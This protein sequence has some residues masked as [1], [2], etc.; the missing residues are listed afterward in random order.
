L[1]AAPECI[2]IV[3][4]YLLRKLKKYR[5]NV[6]QNL[7]QTKM[8]RTVYLKENWGWGRRETDNITVFNSSEKYI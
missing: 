8:V 3:Q 7:K 5:T 4:R 1:E 6:L 2:Y